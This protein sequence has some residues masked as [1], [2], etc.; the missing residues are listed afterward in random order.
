MSIPNLTYDFIITGFGCAGMSIVYHLLD[1]RLKNSQIL[2]IDSSD[3]NTNDRTWCYWAEKPLSIHPK[4]SPIVSWQ[5]ISIRIGKKEVKKQ[6]DELKYYHIKSSEFYSE[7]KQRISLFP[8]VHFVMDNISSIQENSSES[9]SVTTSSS[10]IY[11]GKKIFNSIPDDPLLYEGHNILKQIFVGWKVRTQQPCFEIDSAMMMNF[12]PGSNHKMDFFYLLPFSQTE[13]LIEYT[14]FTTENLDAEKMEL[15]LHAYISQ[16]LSQDKVEISF[17]EVGSIPMTT[18]SFNTTNNP[19]ITHLGTV[20]GC[21]KPST[22]YTF[23]TIQKHC[24]SIVRELESKSIPTNLAFKRKKRF[25]FY[26]NIILNIAKKWPNELPQVFFNLFENNSGP[27]IL[28]FLNE[29][30]S[31][32]NELKLLSRLKFSIF[33]KSLLH[34]EKH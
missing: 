22:G 15:A 6:L 4:N 8:N 11:L 14:V 30:T 3:K 13:A 10:G 32:F 17:K 21:S 24:A 1:S 9:V 12:L 34:F 20:A 26:D 23:H 2:V 7:I 27:E 5:N 33:I 31:F 29:E 19:N 28:R 18:Y 16:N 25:S